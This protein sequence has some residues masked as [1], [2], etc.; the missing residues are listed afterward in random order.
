ML[1]MATTHTSLLYSTVAPHAAAAA[2]P[3]AQLMGQHQLWRPNSYRGIHGRQEEAGK[4]A[5]EDWRQS[6]RPT[7]TT[8]QIRFA[9][10]WHPLHT[11]TSELMPR[12]HTNMYLRIQ[13]TANAHEN[14]TRRSRWRSNTHQ[15]VPRHPGMQQSRWRSNTGMWQII[16]L[17]MYAPAHNISKPCRWRSDK[18]M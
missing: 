15:H 2:Q 18:N 5:A 6:T 4:K 9:K 13:S 3:L 11:T 8:H 16:H 14:T 12:L 7:A 17:K 1:Y 10:P